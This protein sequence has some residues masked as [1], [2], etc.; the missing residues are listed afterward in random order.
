MVVDAKEK[1]K[2]VL[3]DLIVKFLP[4]TVIE[5]E[6]LATTEQESNIEGVGHLLIALYGNNN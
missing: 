1:R 2:D 5:Q 3:V 4:M 6:T